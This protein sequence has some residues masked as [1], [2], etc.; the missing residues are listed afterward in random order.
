MVKVEIAATTDVEIAGGRVTVPTLRRRRHRRHCLVAITVEE[1]GATA[2]PGH[3]LRAMILPHH[4]HHRLHRRRRRK[5]DKVFW[6]KPDHL[7][8]HKPGQAI[9]CKPDLAMQRK[10]DPRS[11]ERRV[12]KECRL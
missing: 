5:P 9:G 6:Y 12:G 11:E 1:V 8:Q 4:H 7:L 10:P 3:A 2:L